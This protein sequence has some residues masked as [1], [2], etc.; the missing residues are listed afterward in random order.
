M[1]IIIASYGV[2]MHRPD[3]SNR[4]KL[5]TKKRKKMMPYSILTRLETFFC[6]LSFVHRAIFIFLLLSSA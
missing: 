1:E 4:R 5:L 6:P 2:K 3:S